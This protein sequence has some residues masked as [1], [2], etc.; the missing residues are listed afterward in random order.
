MKL[1]KPK[2]IIV[3][4]II[5]LLAIVKDI[6]MLVR[7]QTTSD[8]QLFSIVGIGILVP[9]FA[10]ALILMRAITVGYLFKPK[11]LGLRFGLA[12]VA[13]DVIVSIIGWGISV[14]DVASARTAYTV[15]RTAR[16]L[17]VREGHMGF[18]FSPVGFTVTL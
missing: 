8:Y 9:I 11:L 5:F 18:I 16:G 10:G 13:V 15:S 12:S 14:A 3:L 2:T 4:I 17:P 7:Y 6:E 1:K